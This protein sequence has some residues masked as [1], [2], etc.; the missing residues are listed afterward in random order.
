MIHG[1][2]MQR[3]QLARKVA[4]AVARRSSDLEETAKSD[5]DGLRERGGSC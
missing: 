2:G 3:Q 1:A 5:V 4:F